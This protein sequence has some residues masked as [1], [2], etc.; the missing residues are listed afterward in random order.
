MIQMLSLRLRAVLACA[1]LIFII[2]GGALGQ[3]TAKTKAAQIAEVMTLANKYRQFNGS[4]LVADHG[5]VIYKK[6][7]GLA[8]MEW[9]IPNTPETRF[10]LGSITKQ[11]TATAILQLVEQGKIKLDGKISDYLPDYRKDVGEKV[12]IHQLLNHTS[13]IPSYTGLPGFFQDVSRNP[14][15]VDDFIK[16]YASKDLEFEPGSKFSYNNSGYFLLGA[17]IE[18]VTGK[19]Y[20][21]VLKENIFDPLGMKNTGYDHF[22]TLIQK[23]ATGYQ[24]TAN[25]YSNAPYLDMSIPYAAG[26]LYSTVE[27]LYLW[28][29]ALYTDRLL[30]E[31]TKQL[32]F[33]P[34]L[35]NYAYG[36]TIRKTRF[37]E[38]IPVITHNGG[39]NGFSTT[40]IRFPGEKNLIVMLDNTAQG[41]SIDRLS[42]ELTKIL[43]ERPFEL[44]KMSVAEVLFKTINEKGI[45][46]AMAQFQELKAKQANSYD[47]SEQELNR[48]GYQL[49][50]TGK[51][52]EAIEIFKLNVDLYPKAFNTY[53]SLGEA[54]MAAGN[55]ELAIA[56][57]KKSLELNPQNT[58]GT[59][60]LKRLEGTAAP[61]DAKSYEAYVGEYEVTPSF[62]VRMFIE[63]DKLMTQ[64]TNQPAFEL[65]PEGEDKFFLKVV[66]ARV[67]FTKDEKG[68]VTGLIIHQ[69]GRDVPG[70]KIK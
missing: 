55:K 67:T 42:E 4:V 23:R 46:A 25:G 41:N 37:D 32:M 3:Q 34:N 17:I 6:G 40:I 36:W 2:Q 57:Y 12:T 43:Y 20:E 45:T 28:D 44:P 53:D 10:R 64:A 52:D 69:G 8:N 49:M 62:I 38:K 33:K 9:E 19:P 58:N 14:F 5:K 70:K 61:V 27:D 7:L 68:A 47:F 13:G 65:S 29:Q 1:L 63:G 18:K 50:G 31:E 16:K 54:Y 24:K 59:E 26:S 51:R 48:L 39:I 21:Q 66:N 60:M 15:K 35:S 56:N 22:D 30:K 11:F